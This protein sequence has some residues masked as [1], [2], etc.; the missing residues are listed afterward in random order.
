[1]SYS[2]VYRSA[3]V[4]IQ[5]CGPW[6]L[7]REREP[8]LIVGTTCGFA[9]EPSPAIGP[10][11]AFHMAIHPFLESYVFQHA[12]DQMQHKQ[13]LQSSNDKRARAA[14]LALG[15]KIPAGPV[16]AAFLVAFAGCF[17]KCNRSATAQV[18][19]AALKS[20]TTA[21][22]LRDSMLQPMLDT[23]PQVQGI[24]Q[25]KV[26]HL[27][28]SC[29][30]SPEAASLLANQDK[31]ARTITFLRKAYSLVPP[32][33]LETRY[34][35]LFVS[36]AFL[37]A[38]FPSAKL[39]PDTNLD[40][41]LE[42]LTPAM[43]DASTA[44]AR[45][46]SWLTDL[47]TDFEYSTKLQEAVSPDTRAD[48]RFDYLVQILQTL[49]ATQSVSQ[50]LT[51]KLAQTSI[52]QG[53]EAGRSNE[54]RTDGEVRLVLEWVSCPPVI[55]S[56]SSLSLNHRATWPWLLPSS[57]CMPSCPTVGCLQTYSGQTCR[58][59]VSARMSSTTSKALSPPS[60]M[61]VC[62]SRRHPREPTWT[63]LRT[64]HQTGPPSPSCLWTSARRS[65]RF[66]TRARC[67]QARWTKANTCKNLSRAT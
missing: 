67:E 53:S 59:P 14:C 9:P 3:H 54:K 37:S 43:E 56:P 22:A 5:S 41:F 12:F 38:A 18:L 21:N 62:L 57:K 39:D 6:R 19:D 49:Q 48:A 26:A 36:F 10:P 30:V 64:L 13:P 34:D 7:G 11:R 16:N 20:P 55:G 27:L 65:I 58:T 15:R 42:I 32:S 33:E 17:G 40:T 52:A 66:G 46:P 2:S 24:E 25:A 31:A 29:C 45:T 44:D 35:I 28:A 4:S 23:L 60:S 51:S 1:M 47:E 61:V 8:Q 63:P 50:L